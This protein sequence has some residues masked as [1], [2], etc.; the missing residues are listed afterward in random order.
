MY[1]IARC[2]HTQ[3]I[4]SNKPHTHTHI[5][6]QCVESG[7]EVLEY[8]DNMCCYIYMYEIARCTH[9]QCIHSNKP[10]THTHTHTHTVR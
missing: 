10:H 7:C 4:H 2:T 8:G 1:E 6:T 5:H 9:T 3:C